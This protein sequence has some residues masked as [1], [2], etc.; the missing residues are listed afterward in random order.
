V[1]VE[2]QPDELSFTLVSILLSSYRV[3]GINVFVFE[4]V[5]SDLSILSSAS[6]T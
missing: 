3:P 6:G 2:Q 4:S 5:L 1:V